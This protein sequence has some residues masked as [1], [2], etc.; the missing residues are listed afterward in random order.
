MTKIAPVAHS[1]WQD[2]RRKYL[3]QSCCRLSL[4]RQILAHG[5]R[6]SGIG[7]PL[8]AEVSKHVDVLARRDVGAVPD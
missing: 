2:C 6:R 5:T 8:E 7:P 3:R 4:L 1:E